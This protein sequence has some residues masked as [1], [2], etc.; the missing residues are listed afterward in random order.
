MNRFALVAVMALAAPLAPLA[1]SA[2][3]LIEEGGGPYD[4]NSDTV[5]I[6]IVNS[7]TGGAGDYVIEFFSTGGITNALAD[8]SITIIGVGNSFTGLTMS[9]IDGLALNTIVS[10]SGTYQLN[11]QF[12]PDFPVQQ[13]RF[14]WT[15]SEPDAGFGF[16]VTTSMDTGVIPLPASVLLLGSALAGFGVLRRRKQSAKHLA[17]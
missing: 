12:N 16:D 6:G 3:T 15:N 10:T 11:T 5:F 14:D 13:L 7:G 1:V 4:I 17:S 2:S 8:A 9:W